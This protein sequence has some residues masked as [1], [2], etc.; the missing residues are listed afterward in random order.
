MKKTYTNF[1][2]DQI[3]NIS[4]GIPIYT[5]EIA[6]KMQDVYHLS[7]KEA[8]AAASVAIKRVLDGKLVP[9][10]RYF[11][12][13][14]YYRT[15]ITLF[16][17]TGINKEQ[18]IA[19]KYL[20]P[21]RGYESG[22]AILNKLGLT[23]QMPREREFVTNAAKDGTRKDKKLEVIIRP[24]KVKITIEN[25]DYLQILDVLDLLEKAPVDESEPYR[26][27]AEYIQKK[28]LKYKNLLAIAD[29]YYNQ[30]TIIRLAHTASI[31]GIQHETA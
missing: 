8:L 14:I 15:N 29:R 19:D 27:I 11:Q 21:N 12:K 2:C 16:G 7:E 18:L 6:K 25:K 9:N 17:E 23:S 26:V 10:L 30:K 22:L 13:G 28:E 24:P 5:R 31:G 1:V 4:E 3:K 20:L